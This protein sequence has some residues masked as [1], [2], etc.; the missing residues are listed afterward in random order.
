MKIHLIGII[1]FFSIS[2][3]SQ[4]I[5][6]A[7][8]IEEKSITSVNIQKNDPFF[9]TGIFPYLFLNKTYDSIIHR[10]FFVREKNRNKPENFY[11]KS[12]F[13]TKDSDFVLHINPVL[14]YTYA[15]D[16]TLHRMENTRGIIITGQLS[17]KFRFVTGA[18]ETQAF[19][20]Q[21]VNYYRKKNLVIP[22][23][24]RA[25]PFKQTGFD[26]TNSFGYLM[27]SF[28]PQ[29]HVLFGHMRQF[30]GYGYRSVLL[31]DAPFEYPVLRIDYTHK[32]WQYICQYATYQSATEFD[33]RTKVFSRKYSSLHYLSFIP[34]KKIELGIFENTLFH[35]MSLSRNR[36]PEEFYL[37]IL[38]SH[39][40]LYGLNSPNNAM[41][42]FQAQIEPFNKLRFYGQM[43]IDD[44]SKTNTARNKIAW[45]FGMKII[46]PFGLKNFFMLTEYNLSS[47][48]VYTSTEPYSVFSQH[49]E[50]IAHILG[51]YFNEFVIYAYYRYRIAFI[52][53]K[54]NKANYYEREKR[55]EPNPQTER[56]QVEQF[57]I[58]SGFIIH[59]PSRLTLT[60]G[61]HQR[62][63]SF[64]GRDEYIMF[65]LKTRFFNFYDDF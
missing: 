52:L 11:Y 65:G 12:V 2:L 57:K 21:H 50:P 9:H 54:L 3:F 14:N 43:T 56:N 58:E 51:N 42:G 39:T 37:P 48:H 64:S 10:Y 16:S 23:A 27:Y 26:F 45:Q 41:L 61:Y 1:L 60:V 8:L 22:G 29:W 32:R 15:N 17:N 19:Y 59:K 28:N 7:Y 30:V 34:H 31:S 25:R 33:D 53:F 13:Y 5:P 40:L 44:Y 24:G 46:E 63:S 38:L 55:L 47:P 20:R 35:S 4:E 6:I 36:P 62:Q 18:T 49:N